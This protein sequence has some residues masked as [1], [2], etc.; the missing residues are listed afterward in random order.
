MED[1]LG[2]RKRFKN[3]IPLW[4]ILTCLID[5]NF[6]SFRKF[7][8]Y[9]YHYSGY[10]DLRT[11]PSGNYTDEQ[12]INILDCMIKEKI[13]KKNLYELTGLSKNTFNKSFKE[14]FKKHN[15]TN[16]RTFTLHE[17]YQILNEWQGEGK[18]GQLNAI[19]KQT[20]SEIINSG[21]YKKTAEEFYAFMDENSYKSKD[22][23]SPKKIKAFITHIELN[24]EKTEELL[25]YEDFKTSSLF[26][27]GVIVVWLV[28]RQK[29]TTKKTTIH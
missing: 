10:L 2:K 14:Y 6:K 5:Y 23:F 25:G 1:Y 20:L 3:G 9:I 15:L 16:R 26:L 24:K 11:K 17:T 28:C 13:R 21:D 4:F 8:I 22:K 27:F 29:N 18:W 7:L 19:K 12:I